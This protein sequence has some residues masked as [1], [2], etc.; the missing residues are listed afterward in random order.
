MLALTSFFHRAL[1]L[2]PGGDCVA[3]AF[4]AKLKPPAPLSVCYFVFITILCRFGFRTAQ[5]RLFYVC[6][7]QS[8]FEITSSKHRFECSP[9]SGS[10]RRRRVKS[11]PG[12]TRRG[13]TTERESE[14]RRSWRH[15]D[16]QTGCN[17]FLRDLALAAADPSRWFLSSAFIIPTSFGAGTC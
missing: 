14:T 9:R 3:F 10:R 7:F 8:R 15:V 5:V 11:Q 13:K 1:S 16:E 6:A 4:I 17:C 2:R 12:Q